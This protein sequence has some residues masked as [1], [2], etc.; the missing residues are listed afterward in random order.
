MIKLLA[1]LA[2][3]VSFNTQ[4]IELVYGLN[5]SHLKSG[6]YTQNG[7]TEKYNENNRFIAI[8]HSG[9]G[10]ARFTNSFNLDSEMIYKTEPIYTKSL[11]LFSVTGAISYGL[12]T[13]YPDALIS[14]KYMPLLS[15][16]LRVESKR[17]FLGMGLYGP[18]L[19]V[20]TV[21]IG[22]TL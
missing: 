12:I 19:D 13:G 4:S 17:G 16:S 8:Q 15:P 22:F 21:Q 2:A 1:V 5:T 10:L 18:L 7:E 14:D 3:L 20:L 9:Y 6:N 11:G